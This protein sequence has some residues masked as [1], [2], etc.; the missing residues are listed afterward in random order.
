V[1]VSYFR[2][3]Q[4]LAYKDEGTHINAGVI[5]GGKPVSENK[6]EKNVLMRNQQPDTFA[7]V[8]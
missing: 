7:R 4:S 8:N 6:R 2:F 3:T 1:F 5:P